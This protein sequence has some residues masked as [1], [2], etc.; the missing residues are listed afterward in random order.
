MTFDSVKQPSKRRG[1]SK[2]VTRQEAETALA[3]LRAAAELGDTMANWAL[4]S[5]SVEAA[6][7][8]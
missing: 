5:L 7:R 2:S 6:K 3:R 1:P 4:V 8:A